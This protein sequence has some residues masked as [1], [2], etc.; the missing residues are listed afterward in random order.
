[1]LLTKVKISCYTLATPVPVQRVYTGAEIA[2]IFACVFIS[3]C[4]ST[5]S[6][7]SAPAQLW[8]QGMVSSVAQDNGGLVTNFP[9]T[10]DFKRHQRSRAAQNVHSFSGSH[11]GRQDTL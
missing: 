10:T 3:G 5:Q 4:S 2:F 7:A 9:Q 1:M 8:S 11:H 6:T